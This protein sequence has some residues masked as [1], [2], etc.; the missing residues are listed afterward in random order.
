MPGEGIARHAAPAGASETSLL[1]ANRR[2]IALMSSAMSVFIVNDMLIKIVGESLPASQVIGLRGLMASLWIGVVMLASTPVRELRWLLE[3]H[4]LGRCV[5]DVVGTFTYIWA[6]FALP[7]ATATAINMSTPIFITLMAVLWLRES[8]GWR[9]WSAVAAGFLGVMLIVRPSP[10]GLNWWALLAFGA[11]GVHAFRDVYTRRIP[12]GIPSIVITFANALSVGLFG[13]AMALIDAW[14][15]MGWRQWA[16]LGAA[17]LFLAIGYQ[18]VVMAMRA[19]EASVIGAFRYSGLVWA[20]IIGWAV[21]GHVPDPLTW[22]G[23][24]LLVGAGLYI[25]HRERVRARATVER[26]S[27][28]S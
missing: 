11:T 28:A 5:L 26:R 1:A 2:G 13:C 22:S 12:G 23:M 27:S 8:V 4:L 6:L 10:E 18:C 24:A 25:V 15:P 9:R 7:I 14:Q 3:P 21:W 20:V 17:S 16:Y 19:G